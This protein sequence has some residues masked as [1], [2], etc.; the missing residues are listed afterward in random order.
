MFELIKKIYPKADDYVPCIC[1]ETLI[2]KQDANFH[3]YYRG[4]VYEN[5]Y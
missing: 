5:F 1:C 3:V 2:N 4:R